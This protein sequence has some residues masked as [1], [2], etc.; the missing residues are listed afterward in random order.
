MHL[1]TQLPPPEMPQPLPYWHWKANAR[2]ALPDC[3]NCNNDRCIECPECD[4]SGE[5]E[6]DCCGHEDTCE[7]CDGDGDIDCPHCGHL[8]SVRAYHLA[9]ASDYAALLR[10]RG[11]AMPS[12][13]IDRLAAASLRSRY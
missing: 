9:V 13:E 3:D 10:H 11:L 2:A 4:G 12:H 5:T 1:L 8:L 6:C 7:Q